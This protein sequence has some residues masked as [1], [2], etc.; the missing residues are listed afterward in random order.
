MKHFIPVLALIFA[1]SVSALGQSSKQVSWS[2]SSKKIA[3]NTYE[4]HMTANI[5]DDWH[6]YAQNVGVE[7]PLPTTFTFTKNPL[8]IADNKV[9]E[10]GNVIKKKEEVWGGVVHYYEKQVDFV[11]VVK[12]KGNVKT[13]VAGKIEFM[14]CNEERC[15]PPSTIDFKLNI[16]G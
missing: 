11:Q 7:G 15:L 5:D 10:I 14:V 6:L 16:G 13:N 12:L 3:D 9:K 1:T 4:I 2:F 8:L